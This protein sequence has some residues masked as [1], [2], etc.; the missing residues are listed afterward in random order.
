MKFQVVTA[1]AFA[2]SMAV[3]AP[4]EQKPMLAATKTKRAGSTGAELQ[5][6]N[7]ATAGLFG[8]GNTYGNAGIGGFIDATIDSITKAIS[9][10]VRGILAGG[11][12]LGGN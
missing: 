5:H 7:Q 10:P 12:I 11:G 1:I 8:N 4:L 3:A 6:E 2:A 9:S